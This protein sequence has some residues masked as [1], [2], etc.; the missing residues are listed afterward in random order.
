VNVLKPN[1]WS[2]IAAIAVPE[3]QTLT[4]LMTHIAPTVAVSTA[5]SHTPQHPIAIAVLSQ[6]LWYWAEHSEQGYVINDTTGLQLR[7]GQRCRPA[8]AWVSADRWQQL[9][10]NQRAEFPPICPEF[11]VEVHTQPRSI[12][13]DHQK[14]VVYS[15]QGAMQLGWLID[16]EQQRV[17]RYGAN[18]A[19]ICQE[20]PTQIRA[21]PYLED[22]V[23]DFRD[24]W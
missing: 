4:M 7:C 12:A 22:F 5:A 10:W 20:Q 21:S 19:V 6:L 2:I 9:P 23:M 16:P 14:M 13:A 8:A 1:H 18:A 15:Q 24:L 11:I 3:D 17:Y